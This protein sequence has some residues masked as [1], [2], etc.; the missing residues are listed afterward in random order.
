MNVLAKYVYCLLLDGF[1]T[2]S[3]CFVG[4]DVPQTGLTGGHVSMF[5]VCSCARTAVALL[6]WTWGENYSLDSGRDSQQAVPVSPLTLSP[7]FMACIL[8]ALIL[9]NFS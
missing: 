6:A 5:L 1:R 4:S 9:C 7:K 3:S 8:A 2:M